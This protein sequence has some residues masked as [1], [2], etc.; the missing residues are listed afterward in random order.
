MFLIWNDAVSGLFSQKQ[1]KNGK[2]GERLNGC[3][4]DGSGKMRL[5]GLLAET[6]TGL[7]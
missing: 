7:G 3:R 5:I 2:A 4:P 1:A 6:L